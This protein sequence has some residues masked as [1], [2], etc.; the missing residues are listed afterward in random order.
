V[1]EEV[2]RSAPARTS[3]DARRVDQDHGSLLIVPVGETVGRWED[4]A[5]LVRLTQ[6][7]PVAIF[8]RALAPLPRGDSLAEAAAFA[9]VRGQGTGE[10]EATLRLGRCRTNDVRISL[11]KQGT[12]IGYEAIVTQTMASGDNLRLRAPVG[13]YEVGIEAGTLRSTRSISV[14]V[15][16]GQMESVRLTA[17]EAAEEGSPSQAC[18]RAR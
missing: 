12:R 14:S 10:V 17:S 7:E 9:D 6:D 8:S 5:F 3:A 11:L 1:R 4:D 15:K 18:G 16:P 2:L 13:V